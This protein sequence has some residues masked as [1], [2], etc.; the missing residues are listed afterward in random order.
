MAPESAQRAYRAA[1]PGCGAPVEF[2][3]AQSTHA[4]CSF[5][6][7]TVVRSGDVLSRVG[8]MAELFDDFSPLQLQTSG[9]Y[10]L[11]NAAQK[12]TLI[13]RLQYKY[14]QGTWTEWYALFDDAAQSVGFLSE[15]NGAYVFTLPTAL[16]LAAPPADQLRV[17]A[18]TAIEGK[19][20]SV[21]S[22]DNV[23]LMSAQG[24]LPHLPQLGVQF[25]MVELRS[26]NGEV[27]SI[28]YGTAVN[29][30]APSVSR[31]R[32]VLLG[33]LKL[34]G[35]RDAAAKDEKGQ[36]F[37]CPHCGAQVAITLAGTKSITCASCN[38]IIDV[39]Q[40]IGA[41]L[42]LAQQD[43]PVVLLVPLGSTG[44]L[45]GASWQVLGFQHRMGLEP[46]DDE[47]FG[48]SE[49]LLYNRQRGFTF[50]VDA[51][52]GWSLVKPVTGA[53]TYKPGTQSAV[54]L[55]TTYKLLSTYKAETNY[56]AG[57][58]YWQVKRGEQTDNQDFSNGKA[59]LSREATRTEITWSS[60]DKL[61]GDVVA[62][63]FK[64]D[65]KKELFKRA[66]AQPL[67]AA[68]GMSMGTIVV[69]VIILLVILLLFSR[70]SRCNPALE[71][72][73]SSSSARTSGGSFGGSSSGGGHK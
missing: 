59:M 21:A 12:F 25:A 36:A 62:K 16:Q 29:G 46:G 58:F 32:A 51:E 41:A 31:G 28:D 23:A 64:L 18:T 22:M 48:W 47:Q 24:E 63:A 3:S 54:Y 4:V 11:G 40:G 35:L 67:S 56:V 69:V 14:G 37:A 1:C 50:L 71:N 8:K 66:D 13:G 53:P 45:Q 44:Q 70:C 68:A 39:S 7:S 73:S 38:S 5:C 26:A 72:C 34:T 55:G 61:A 42:T 65:G 10:S 2:R 27:L 20:F 9:V 19:A 57:E 49:Y 17:G 15:D 6:Q 60:G 43:E 52:D 30:G 33:D